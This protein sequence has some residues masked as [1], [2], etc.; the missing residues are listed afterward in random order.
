MS[1][2]ETLATTADVAYRRVKSASWYNW[3]KFS[4]RLSREEW[5]ENNLNTDEAKAKQKNKKSF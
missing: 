1:M 4:H 2:L 5:G 3:L